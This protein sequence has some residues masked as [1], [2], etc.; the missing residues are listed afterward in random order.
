MD[1]RFEWVEILLLGEIMKLSNL[2]LIAKKSGAFE[3][4][5]YLIEKNEASWTEIISEIDVPASTLQRAIKHLYDNRI[6]NKQRC[7][8]KVKYTLSKKF[9]Y[10][11]KIS[12]I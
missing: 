10:L 9:K 7:G 4:I 8:K 2:N 3:V 11:R 12:E 5:D 1:S 6:I